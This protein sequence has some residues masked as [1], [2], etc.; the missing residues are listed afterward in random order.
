[1]AAAFVHLY[2]WGRQSAAGEDLK[3]EP[4]WSNAR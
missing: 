2:T 3:I 4:I 1:M